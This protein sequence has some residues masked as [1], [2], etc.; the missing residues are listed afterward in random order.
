[1]AR[2][3]SVSD[4]QILHTVRTCALEKGAN[5]S[6]ED[7][8]GKLGVS[9]PALLKRFGT[10]EEMVFAALK[11]PDASFLKELDHGPTRAPLRAQL[12]E[13]IA[14]FTHFFSSVFPCMMVLRESGIAWNKMEC[15]QDAPPTILARKA[16]HKWLVR[17]KATGLVRATEVETAASA[18]IGAVIARIA[19][20]H[21]GRIP[22]NSAD[23]EAFVDELA[24]LFSRAL[25]SASTATAPRR[26]KASLQ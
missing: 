19:L 9:T 1:M 6:L 22:F 18:M 3:R 16:I 4:D 8:A 24:S 11:P 7:V 10:R 14:V 20:D 26:K 2:P 25:S 15:L 5:F 17:A 23:Q 21:I 13:M 12:R